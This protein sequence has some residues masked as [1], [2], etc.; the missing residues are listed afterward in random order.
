MMLEISPKLQLYHFPKPLSEYLLVK[1]LSSPSLREKM[2]DLWNVGFDTS[3]SKISEC[4]KLRKNNPI[5]VNGMCLIPAQTHTKNRDSYSGNML[6]EI[7]ESKVALTQLMN[8]ELYLD[9]KRSR[10]VWRVCVDGSREWVTL[11]S[12]LAPVAM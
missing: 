5:H 12:R 7:A 2:A 10:G 11:N 9:L 6:T 1:S 8:N 4:F 3:G